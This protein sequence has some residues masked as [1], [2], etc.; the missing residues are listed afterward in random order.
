M[1]DV[2]PKGNNILLV[3][4]TCA[5]EED[6]IAWYIPHL[7]G[8]TQTVLEYA[9][10][11]K[12]TIVYATMR[13]SFNGE[14]MVI[15]SWDNG[16]LTLMMSFNATEDIL[17]LTFNF[18]A[19]PCDMNGLWTGEIATASVEVLLTAATPLWTVSSKQPFDLPEYGVR[20]E[21]ITVTGT[22]LQSY[23]EL[24]YI[25]TDIE[26]ANQ[27]CRIEI[28]DAQG[29]ALPRGVLGV[30]GSDLHVEN[31][32]LITWHGGFGATA[33]APAQLMLCFGSYESAEPARILF[34]LQ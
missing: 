12:Q 22:V 2:K 23:Y 32:Q 3:D 24:R 5:P 33:E 6:Q 27:A 30:G 31:G 26:K 8:S 9:V 18:T 13:N 21:G 1:V 29:Q 7:Q 4:E 10:E 28:L 14:C 19:L 15:D 34:N 16:I 11:H 25:I 17:P 20:I